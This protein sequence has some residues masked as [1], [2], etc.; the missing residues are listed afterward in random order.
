MVYVKDE[1]SEHIPDLDNLKHFSKLHFSSMGFSKLHFSAA[2]NFASWIGEKKAAM[3]ITGSFGR[4]FFSYAA[5][6][7]FADQVIQDHAMPLFIA[8]T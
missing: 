5:R 7:S 2:H 3:L 4:S 8:H 6:R 1:S